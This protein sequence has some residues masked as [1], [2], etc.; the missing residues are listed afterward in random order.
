MGYEII[1][2]LAKQKGISLESIAEY[3]N[4]SYNSLSKIIRNTIKAPRYSTIKNIAEALNMSIDELS[5]AI[6]MTYTSPEELQIP[7]NLTSEEQKIVDKFRLL[8][9]HGQ[10]IVKIVLNEEYNRIT[11]ADNAIQLIY[12][13]DLIVGGMG[14][15]GD[16]TTEYI[17]I[18]PNKENIKADFVICVHGIAMEPTYYDGDKLYV[19]QCSNIKRGEVGVFKVGKGCVIRE[20]GKDKLLAHNSIV[21]DISLDQDIICIGRVLCKME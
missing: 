3:A 2:E 11:N 13:P 16:K 10:K 17:N 21:T 6:G 5:Y 12:Y 4:I 18:Y 15:V 8:D 20:L 1:K 14:E 19:A 9:K 7:A